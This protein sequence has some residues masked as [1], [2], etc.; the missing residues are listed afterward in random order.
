M[1]G[2][3]KRTDNLSPLQRLFGFL[4]KENSITP[5]TDKLKQ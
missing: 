3:R 2:E 1:E 5:N 4:K